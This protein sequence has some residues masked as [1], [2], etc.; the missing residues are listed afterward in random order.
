MDKL[1]FFMDKRIWLDIGLVSFWIAA[2]A[3]LVYFLPSGML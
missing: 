1:D 3:S 2:W